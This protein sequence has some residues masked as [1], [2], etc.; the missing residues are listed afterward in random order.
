[1]F[2]FR[3]VAGRRRGE[4]VG[5]RVVGRRDEDDGDEREDRERRGSKRQGAKRLGDRGLVACRLGDL[6]YRQG[7]RQIEVHAV[8]AE[9]AVEDGAAQSAQDQHPEDQL[10]YRP[11]A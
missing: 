11:A 5:G 8:V 9:D 10:P 1:M 2:A 3:Q 6:A 4:A 7:P